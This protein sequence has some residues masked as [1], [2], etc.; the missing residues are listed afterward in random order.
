[1]KKFGV[2]YQYYTRSNHIKVAE[3]WYKTAEARAKALD[4]LEAEDKLH[5]VLAYSEE[6]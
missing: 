1:M 4:K 3:R 5:Q 2:R 6:E